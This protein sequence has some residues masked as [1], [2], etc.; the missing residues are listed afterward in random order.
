M[1]LVISEQKW[2]FGTNFALSASVHWGI[3]IAARWFTADAKG[4]EKK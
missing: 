3:R 1:T 2:G 4:A